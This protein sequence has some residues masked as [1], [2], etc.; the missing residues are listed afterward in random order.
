MHAATTIAANTEQRRLALACVALQLA[1]GGIS[2]EQA[3]SRGVMGGMSVTDVQFVVECYN[4]EP[5]ADAL[6]VPPQQLQ[7]QPSQQ[8]DDGGAVNAS[9]AAAKQPEAERFGCAIPECPPPGFN[10]YAYDF[11]DT[12]GAGGG[13]LGSIS[14]VAED[15]TAGKGVASAAWDASL[16]VQPL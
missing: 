3:I 12:S 6:N 7:L 1:R 4:A 16:Q 2:V 11:F 14:D 8:P 15:M 9:A 10:A 5:S 13:G